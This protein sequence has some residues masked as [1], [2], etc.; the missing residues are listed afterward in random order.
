[1]ALSSP[2]GRIRGFGAITVGHVIIL[3]Q[4]FLS[5]TAPGCSL[6][7]SLTRGNTIGW[8]QRIC[9]STQSCRPLVSCSISFARLPSSRLGMPTIH[10]NGY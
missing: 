5:C 9:L 1:M 2:P 4:H 8:A 7:N 10:W 6:T 3:S